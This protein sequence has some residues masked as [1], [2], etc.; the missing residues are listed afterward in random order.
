MNW[1]SLFLWRASFLRLHQILSSERPPS[2]MLVVAL[3]IIRPKYT[4]KIYSAIHYYYNDERGI[5]NVSLFVHCVPY[6]TYSM[7]RIQNAEFVGFKTV[8]RTKNMESCKISIVN[9]IFI[10]FFLKR[11]CYHPPD[12]FIFSLT[13]ADFFIGAIIMPIGLCK[14]RIFCLKP[15]WWVIIGDLSCPEVK[16]DT[17][18]MLRQILL[19]QKVS[20]FLTKELTESDEKG[21][22]GSSK[23]HSRSFFTNHV[24][25]IKMNYFSSPIWTSFWRG[26]NRSL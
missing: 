6:W 16:L 26:Q 21:L 15:G 12:I 2:W 18:Y 10:R 8:F 24:E 20:I 3:Q 5:K 11:Q 23:V 17:F 7:A 13:I 9:L 25:F 1:L 22:V 19:Q 14:V 4:Q